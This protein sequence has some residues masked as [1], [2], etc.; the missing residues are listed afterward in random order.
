MIT[1]LPNADLFRVDVEVDAA[2]DCIMV[3]F[4]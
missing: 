3:K 4:N 2:L 1:T